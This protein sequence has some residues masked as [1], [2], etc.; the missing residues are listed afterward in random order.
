MLKNIDK[1]VD[2]IKKD[3]NSDSKIIYRTKFV[4]HSKIAIIYNEYLTDSDNISHFI[5]RSIN[6]IERKYK[7]KVD[8]LT[9]FK[10]D[11]SMNK[12]S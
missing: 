1:I 9:T 5:I 7:N 8:L 4:N 11:I 6:K 2:K 12:I 10:N 3:T